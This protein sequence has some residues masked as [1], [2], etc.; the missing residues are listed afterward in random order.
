MD[1]ISKWS[2]HMNLLAIETSEIYTAVAIRSDA[3]TLFASKKLGPRDHCENLSAM[4]KFGLE[5]C[6]LAVNDL[7]AVCV[8]IGPGLFTGLRVGVSTANTLSASAGIP[9]VGVISCDAVALG[10]RVANIDNVV[11]AMDA[12]RKEIYFA[13]YE[14]AGGLNRLEGPVLMSPQ[15]V[16]EKLEEKT[17]E[18]LLTGSAAEAVHHSLG[19]KLVKFEPAIPA[20]APVTVV[21][22][23]GEDILNHSGAVNFIEPLYLRDPDAVANWNKRAL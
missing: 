15:E 3:K 8:D 1:E 20:F 5:C 14:I 22:E 18:T 2:E 21:A 4:I 17:C 12:K 23:I 13:R 11:V 6:D 10:A 19:N 7:D 9:I 16:V